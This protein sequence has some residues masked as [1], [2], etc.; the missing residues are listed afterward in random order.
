MVAPTPDSSSTVMLNSSV[1]MA[2]WTDTAPPASR[3]TS[4]AAA[5][6][7]DRPTDAVAISA[8]VAPGCRARRPADVTA[9]PAGSQACRGRGHA[10]G[11]S[12]SGAAGSRR[13]Q[14]RLLR[15]RLLVDRDD[16]G[17]PIEG[18]VDALAVR[19]VH[20]HPRRA[21]GDRMVA[22]EDRELARHPGLEALLDG[23]GELVLR[24]RWQ[25]EL[26]AGER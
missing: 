17:Q 1:A 5:I 15:E 22:D 12:W 11:S 14:A 9:V 18:M 7:T 16:D 4:I 25:L 20:V 3:M 8:E 23:P 26:L 13:S 21:L 2:I 6:A 24:E 10:A 19:S